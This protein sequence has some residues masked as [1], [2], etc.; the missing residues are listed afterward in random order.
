MTVQSRGGVFRHRGLAQLLSGRLTAAFATQIQAIV[1]AWQVY[2][3]THNPLTLGYVGLAQFLPMVALTLPAGDLADR[4]ERRKI[5]A[6]SWVL[7]AMASALFLVL[8]L[9]HVSTVSLFYGVL[10]LFGFSRAFA[11]P[12]M[13]SFLPLLVPT[14]DL[15]RAIAW[16]SSA[17]QIAII[18]GPALGGAVYLLGPDVAYALCL[19]LFA[20]AAVSVF[21]IGVRIR[22]RPGRDRP[23]AFRRFTAGI[24]YVKG[25]PIVLGAISLDLFAVLFG[26]ATALL[27]VYAYNIL[28]VGSL[29]LGALRSAIAVGAFLMG[30][31]LGRQALARRVGPVMFASVAIFGAATI[32]FGLSR[33]FAVSMA[34]LA[35][36]G[37]ADMISV[38]VRTSL[39]QLATPD[40]MRGRVSAVNMLFIGASNELGEFES[41]VTASWFGSVP[42]VIIGGIG[43]LVVTGVWMWLFPALR[44]VNAMSDVQR[45]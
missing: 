3:M 26:G 41:G 34:A 42:A 29:G 11:G 24:R 20:L 31:Y 35:V 15:G 6:F 44:R 45:S 22:P 25:Q 30:L 9:M 7:Q 13:Q 21:S 2:G 23:S 27:P 37:A 43:T 17:F 39:I 19:T 36:A 32:V 12:A 1:V 10:A 4:V 8:T 38:Y 5:L 33:D 40:E 28:H 18:G 16:N 14:E